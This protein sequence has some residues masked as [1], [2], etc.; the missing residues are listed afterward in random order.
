M[1]TSMEGG[2]AEMI[3]AHDG[4]CCRMRGLEKDNRTDAPEFSHDLQDYPD[5]VN[6]ATLSHQDEMQP[7]E[8]IR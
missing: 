8:P 6:Y 3:S 4:A 1:E 5:L 2:L 7:T